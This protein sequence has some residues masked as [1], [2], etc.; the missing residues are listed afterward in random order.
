MNFT[1]VLLLFSLAFSKSALSGSSA[2]EKNPEQGTSDAIQYKMIPV[3]DTGI[4]FPRLSA[5]KDVTTMNRVNAKIDESAKDF[6][7][8]EPHGKGNRYKVFARV[9]YAAQDIFSVYASANYYCG[10]PYPTNDENV[11]LTFDLRTGKRVEFSELFKNYEANKDRIL[12][13]IFSGQLARTGRLLAGKNKDENSSCEEDPGLFTIDALRDSEYAYNLSE[14][15]LAVQPRWPHVVEA[16]A[17]R[18]TVP[19]QLLKEFVAPNSILVR[20][21]Q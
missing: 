17:E 8:S 12:K 9:E 5:Y 1:T 11:S 7:C 13:I 15:G 10:G 6:A 21:I 3:R 19:Y 14:K 2:H 18:V 20:V 16:C 4:Q